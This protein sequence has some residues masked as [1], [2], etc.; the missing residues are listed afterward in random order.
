[1]NPE[2]NFIDWLI[3]QDVLKQMTEQTFQCWSEDAGTEIGF[4]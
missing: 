4:Y 1:M 3:L 2:F